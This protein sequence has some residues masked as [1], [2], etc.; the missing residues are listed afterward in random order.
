MSLVEHAVIA[1]AGIG[2]R[3]GYGTPKCL[4]E[5]GGQTL[6]AHQLALLA[7]VKDVRLVV[8]FEMDKVIKAARAIRKDIIFRINTAYRTTTTSDSY[9]MGA[10]GLDGYCLFMDADILFERESFSRFCAACTTGQSRIG[11]TDTKTDDAVFAHVNELDEIV[12]FSREERS[13]HEWA[14]LAWLPSDYFGGHSGSAYARI[15]RDLPLRIGRL[16]SYEID[17]EADLHRAR[18][19]VEEGISRR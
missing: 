5:V 4:L 19:F 3:L 14:N 16:D 13:A 1:A 2:S 17:T 7:E 8:G 9:A 6:L 12:R 18:N 15:A 11:V 10:D